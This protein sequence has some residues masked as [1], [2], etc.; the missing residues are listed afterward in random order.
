[1]AETMDRVTLFPPAGGRISFLVKQY[2][3]NDK[4][5][6]HLTTME[7]DSFWTTLQYAIEPD[8]HQG[9]KAG[10]FAEGAAK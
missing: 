2:S 7:G 10:P 3:F 8:I 9:Q 5:V 1:M 4:G 6:L